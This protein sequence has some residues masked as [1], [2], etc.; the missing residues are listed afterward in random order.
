[1]TLGQYLYECRTTAHRSLPK[2]A[3]ELF[4]TGKFG[5]YKTGLSF[6]KCVS[7]LEKDRGERNLTKRNLKMFDGRVALWAKA[8]WTEEAMLHKLLRQELP[9]TEV[10]AEGEPK[11][12]NC[13]GHNLFITFSVLK[14]Y[15]NITEREFERVINFVEK[16]DFVPTEEIIRAYVSQIAKK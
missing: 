10:A 15:G 3:A 4:A 16:L 11:A 8:Y 5:Q 6:E 13:R 2:V 12:R 9:Q 14:G 1:M 7:N